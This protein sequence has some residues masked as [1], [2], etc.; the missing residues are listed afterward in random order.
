MGLMLN[1]D[2]FQNF[3][4]PGSVRNWLCEAGLSDYQAENALNSNTGAG[5]VF[6]NSISGWSR[7][8]A[9]FTTPP[10]GDNGAGAVEVVSGAGTAYQRVQ[11]AGTQ[12]ASGSW[13]TSST[14]IVLSGTAASWM[15][16]LSASGSGL[17]VYDLNTGQQIGQAASVTTSSIILV[18]AALSGSPTSADVLQMS[19][20][21]L[22]S[23][24]LG[25]EPLTAPASAQNNAGLVMCSAAVPSG[26]GTVNSWG[27]YDASGG[28]TNSGNF[29]TWDYLGAYKWIPFSATNASPSVFT[30]DAAAD[31]PANGS[32]VVVTQKFGGTLPTTGGSFSGLLTTAGLSTNT[33]NVGVNSTSTGGGQFR[34]VQQLVIGTGIGPITFAPTN[35]VLNVA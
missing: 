1:R 31:A 35:L 2:D 21:P 34:Q 20:F 14:A 4:W 29:I 32:L 19:I 18:S 6:A 11:I 9:L 8:F 3:C 17:N 12:K 16:A 33:F 28:A 26:W 22:A 24:S 10:S 23:A 5:G 7:W 30:T 25:V 15:T 13:T 27:I